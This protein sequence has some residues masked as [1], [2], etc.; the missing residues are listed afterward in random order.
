MHGR[1]SGGPPELGIEEP[2]V[3]LSLVQ[4]LRPPPQ[5]LAR[6]S[7]TDFGQP[8]RFGKAKGEVQSDERPLIGIGRSRCVPVVPRRQGRELVAREPL[9]HRFAPRRSRDAGDA[10]SSRAHLRLGDEDALGRDL[11][12]SRPVDADE[13]V[14]LARRFTSVGGGQAY[15]PR[16]WARRAIS[17]KKHS[18]SFDLRCDPGG[19]EAVARTATTHKWL[20]FVEHALAREDGERV[21]DHPG[22][23]L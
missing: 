1:R 17:P 15:R 2:G 11:T 5:L 18:T 12:R 23:G 19:H 21:E 13:A 10:D 3:E 9:L 8:E 4:L 20:Y 22:H 14:E 16:I 7:G 6:P